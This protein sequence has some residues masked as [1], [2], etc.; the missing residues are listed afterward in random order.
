MNTLWHFIWTYILFR[1]KPY[2]KKTL[3]MAVI[4][5]APWFISNI[6]AYALYGFTRTAFEVAWHNPYVLAAQYFMNSF[7]VIGFIWI[8]LY[9]CKVHHWLPYIYGWAFHAIIDQLT[10]VSD[11]YPIFWPLSLNVY[12]S[13]I[14][15]WERQFFS[16]EFAII[17]LVVFTIVA[18]FLLREKHKRGFDAKLEVIVFAL[19]MV[20]VFV[21]ALIVVLLWGGSW[22]YVLYSIPPVILFGLLLRHA[23]YYAKKI[24]N[25]KT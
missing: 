17:N 3:W 14:S 20:M 2:V 6:I 23:I 11:A 25:K 24:R 15:Y 8:V 7:V 16:R 13:W 22:L 18:I 19:S 10:H 12:P 4:P 9:F 1:R 21:S 5:D